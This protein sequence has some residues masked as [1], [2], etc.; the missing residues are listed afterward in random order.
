MSSDGVADGGE[1]G[2]SGAGS[3]VLY[4]GSGEPVPGGWHDG[5]PEKHAQTQVEDGVADVYG[6]G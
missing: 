5:V 6:E 1:G 3:E 2:D 4:L